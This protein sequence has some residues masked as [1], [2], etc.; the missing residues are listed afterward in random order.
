MRARFSDVPE[1]V[2]K[3]GENGAS[4]HCTDGETFEQSHVVEVVDVVGAGDAFAGGYLASRLSGG[5]MSERLRAG[6]HR[7]ALTLQTTG[8]SIEEGTTP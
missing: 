3:D 7:A 1:L 4:V 6:H 5:T 8:D 2:V